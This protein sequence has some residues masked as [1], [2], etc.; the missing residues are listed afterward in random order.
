[1]INLI[2]ASEQDE[3]SESLSEAMSEGGDSGLQASYD[4][5][6]G[7]KVLWENRTNGVG[8]VVFKGW[9]HQVLCY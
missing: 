2:L 1:M 3:I 7:R 6:Q 9:T 8:G 4:Q 5:E